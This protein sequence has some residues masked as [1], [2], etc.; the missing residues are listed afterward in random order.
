MNYCRNK[1]ITRYVWE[2]YKKMGGELELG[3][4]RKARQIVQ[5]NENTQS[6]ESTDHDK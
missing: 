6:R 1:E 3:E 5:E 2:N 4:N